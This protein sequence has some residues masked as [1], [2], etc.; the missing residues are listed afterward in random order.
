MLEQFIDTIQLDDVNKALDVLSS[1]IEM[2][3][4]TFLYIHEFIVKNYLNG[5]SIKKGKTGRILV[6]VLNNKRWKEY[7]DLHSVV[8]NYAE[9]I[10][11]E[12]KIIPNAESVNSNVIYKQQTKYVNMIYA[13]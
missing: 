6:D 10:S 5:G 13:V 9:F 12:L 2:D 1:K 4:K 3:N 8:F 7:S 11:N